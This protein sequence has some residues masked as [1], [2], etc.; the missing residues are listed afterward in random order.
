MNKIKVLV[1]DDSSL[2][3]AF[4]GE[5]LEEEFNFIESVMANNGEEAKIILSG[6]DHFE[7]VLCDWE[8]PGLNGNEL[9]RWIREDSHLKTLPFIM[10]TANSEGEGI[11]EVMKLGVTD[12]IVKPFSPEILCQKVTQVLKT[13]AHKST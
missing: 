9:L 8:M 6:S 12:Y 10:I 1:A 2:M 13:I 5:T 7:L 3:R 11:V 4:I